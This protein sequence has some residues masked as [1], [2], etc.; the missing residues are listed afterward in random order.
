MDASLAEISQK[1]E[2][3]VI[4]LGSKRPTSRNLLLRNN[5]AQANKAKKYFT[6]RDGNPSRF[7][8]P[9]VIAD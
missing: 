4:A 3:Y 5:A 7:D 9:S 6:T 2:V 8:D 1:N